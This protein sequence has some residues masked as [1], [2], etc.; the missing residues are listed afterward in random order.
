MAID[1]VIFDK[2][3]QRWVKFTPDGGVSFTTERAEASIID[4][5]QLNAYI[6]DYELNYLEGSLVTEPVE[7]GVSPAT[8]SP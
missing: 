4:P 1:A 2:Q 5:E 7:P 8:S 3:S 6:R